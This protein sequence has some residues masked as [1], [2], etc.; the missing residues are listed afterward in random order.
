MKL[1]DYLEQREEFQKNQAQYRTLCTQCF[2]PSFGCYCQNVRSFDPKIEFVILIHPIEAR[3]RIATGRM[4]HLC[5]QNSHL[6][7]GQN[8]SE[9]TKVNLLL[10]DPQYQPMILYPGANSFNLTE[11]STEDIA[12]LFQ[13]NKKLLLFV[14]DGTWA[15]ARKMMRQSHNLHTLPKICFTP[16]HPSNF[17]VRKQPA[18]GCYSTIEAIHQTIELLGDQ[19]GF[20][21]KMRQHDHLLDVFDQMVQRQLEFIKKAVLSNDPSRYRQEAQRKAYKSA[22]KNG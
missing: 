11:K 15:T 19:F 2:Q 7:M 16:S 8:Y 10:E 17:Q 3:R 4:S 6:I 1:N 5:L 14:I 22:L 12:D 9:N 18:P 20:E 21:T 13:P